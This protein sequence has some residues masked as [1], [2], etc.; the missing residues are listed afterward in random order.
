M[1]VTLPFARTPDEC[2]RLFAACVNSGDLDGLIALY[3]PSARYVQ[4]NGTVLCGHEEIR[5]VLASVTGAPATLD[6]HIVRMVEADGIAVV[7]NDWS[8]LMTTDGTTVQRAG[9]AIEVV[10][11]NADG[12]WLF[13]IDE[14]FG[15]DAK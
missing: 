8:L 15:R 14:P 6:I 12:H 3:E 7:Y 10:R 13:A 1:N 9:K 4:R 11:R 2:D 5:R